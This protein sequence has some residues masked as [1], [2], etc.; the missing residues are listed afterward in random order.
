MGPPRAVKQKLFT[1]LPV[2]ILVGVVPCVRS[3][4]VG[5]LVV[6]RAAA[7]AA[8]CILT[9]ALGLVGL[10]HLAK[11]S[12]GIGIEFFAGGHHISEVVVHH[13]INI[14]E[15]RSV[16]KGEVIHTSL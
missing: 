3:V 9:L 16:V 15:K 1:D 4:A 5:Y 2:W 13:G 11:L 7:T 8:R 10:Y 14:T 12:L 6:G